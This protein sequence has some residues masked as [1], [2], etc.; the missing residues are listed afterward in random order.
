MSSLQSCFYYILVGKV[1]SII[2]FSL[3]LMSMIL[4]KDFNSNHFFLLLIIIG[5]AAFLIGLLTSHGHTGQ[6]LWANLLVNGYFFFTIS[7]FF[8]ISFHFPKYY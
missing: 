6:R 5:L 7:S 4:R 3:G 1:V 8:H 2:F